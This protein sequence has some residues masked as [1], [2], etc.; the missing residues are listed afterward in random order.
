MGHKKME[1]ALTIGTRKRLSPTPRGPMGSLA[2]AQTQGETYSGTLVIA[3][4][5]NC[6]PSQ[7]CGKAGL[8]R[9]FS[10]GEVLFACLSVSRWPHNS[11]SNSENNG[12]LSALVNGKYHNRASVPNLNVALRFLG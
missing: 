9:C 7:L 11:T 12:G 8:S 5:K 6:P 3:P 1:P 4:D 2:H 10:H